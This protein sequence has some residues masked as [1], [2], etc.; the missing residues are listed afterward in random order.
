MDKVIN[1]NIIDLKYCVKENFEFESDYLDRTVIIDAYLPK[2]ISHPENMTLLLVNDG[3]D[4]V[5][6]KFENILEKLYATDSISPILAIGLHCNADRKLEYG[7]ADVIDYQNRGSRAKYYRKFILKELLPYLHTTYYLPQ[8]KE[9]AYA[10]FS[11]GGLGAMDI[12]WANPDIFSTVGVFSGSLWWR[13][14][15]LNNNYNEDTDRIMHQIVRE[16]KYT[17]NMRFFFQ[18]GTADEKMDRNNNG[19]I[20]SIDDTMALID[21]LEK[22]GYK[23]G[24]NIKYLELKDGKH[25]IETWAKAFPDFLKWGWGINNEVD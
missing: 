5:K 21:E 19:I 20:D 1:E 4:L 22:H 24:E 9:I 6:F 3:Q 12:A 8:L 13:T 16:G 15:D 10:G 23:N 11:L 7:T 18:T 14:K 25:N 2:N 17:E